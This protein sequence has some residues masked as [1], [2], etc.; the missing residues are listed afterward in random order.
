MMMGVG[1]ENEDFGIWRKDMCWSTQ[2]MNKK[3]D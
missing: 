3:W 1:G 2:E